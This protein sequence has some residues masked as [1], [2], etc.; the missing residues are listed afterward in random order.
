MRLHE[1]VSCFAPFLEPVEPFTLALKR[2][3][4][5]L[6]VM[7]QKPLPVPHDKRSRPNGLCD[8]VVFGFCDIMAS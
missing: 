4:G 1:A 8:I 5:L 3:A 2:F 6:V 7:V